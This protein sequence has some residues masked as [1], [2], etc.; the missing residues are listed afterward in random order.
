MTKYR[1]DH[2]HNNDYVLIT[3]YK[4]TRRPRR[5]RLGLYT[6]TASTTS[7]HIDR[8]GFGWWVDLYDWSLWYIFV[9]EYTT[10]HWIRRLMKNLLK[11]LPKRSQ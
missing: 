11:W 3:D 7:V 9:V 4:R 6:L 10:A 1:V 2:R 8:D 5:P